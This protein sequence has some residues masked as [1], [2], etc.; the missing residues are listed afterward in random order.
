MQ[1]VI[2]TVGNKAEYEKGIA[3]KAAKGERLLKRGPFQN[4]RE[5]YRGGAV[6]Q[7]AAG[8]QTFVS[9]HPDDG[10]AVFGVEA[11]WERDTIQYD[12]ESFRRLIIDR[13]LVKLQ[14]E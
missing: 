3:D 11:K 7:D 5:R 10:L 14:E 6:W 12:G 9:E 13:A 4:G 2:Y 8:A 1:G